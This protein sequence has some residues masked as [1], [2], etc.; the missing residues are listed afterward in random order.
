MWTF[1]LLIFLLLILYPILKVGFAVWRMRRQARK[2]YEEVMR[3]QRTTEQTTPKHEKIFGSD[4]G[5]YVEFEEIDDSANDTNEP[6]D[7]KTAPLHPSKRRK[8]II[9]VEWEDVEPTA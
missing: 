8:R 4:V 6:A 2:L 3:Q 5:E 9:D 7:D 1:L